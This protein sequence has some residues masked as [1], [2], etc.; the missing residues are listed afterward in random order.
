MKIISL[1]A[2]IGACLLAF[3]LAGCSNG[4]TAENTNS[5]M[6]GQTGE[7]QD[8]HVQTEGKED[9]ENSDV[10]FEL[11]EEGKVEEA[12]DVPADEEKAILHT[13]DQYITTFNN[14]DI[15]GYL[16]LLLTEGEYFNEQE[17]RT[18]LEEVFSNFEVKREV[19]LKTINK[20]EKDQAQ[21]YSDLLLTTTDPASGAEAKRTGRQIT[22]LK[23][24]DD[25]WKIASIHFMANPS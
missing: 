4:D 19:E 7:G 9:A 2:A 13:F 25:E 23:K 10:G 24:V 5:S 15:E 8:T 21:V 22:V 11:N 18:A 12:E 14:E 16:A 6:D 1:K 3:I 17:E 20:F